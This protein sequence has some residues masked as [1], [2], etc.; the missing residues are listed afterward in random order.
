MF[1][2]DTLW[3]L[4]GI[5]IFAGLF[6][7]L[8]IFKRKLKLSFTA[9]VAIAL[10]LGIVFGILMQVLFN[11]Q[12]TAVNAVT[13]ADETVVTLGAT[14]ESLRKWINIVGTGFTKLLQFVVTP[15]VAVSI[16]T[17]FSKT[18]GA[19]GGVK[20]SALIIGFLLLTTA[21]SAVITIVIMRIS[22][23]NANNLIAAN[24]SVKEP[25]DIPTTILGLIP[26]NLF[27]A[28]SSN[29]VLSVV[30]IAVLIG[31][32]YLVIR[33]ESPKIG[34]RFQSFLDTAREF[35]MQVVD[36]VIGLTPYGVL[37]VI[38][39]RAATASWRAIT[40]LLSIIGISFVMMAVVFIL[41]LALL[42][43]LGTNPIRFFKKASPALLF[44]F[45]SRSS[46]ATLPLTI[47]AQRKLGVSDANANIAGTLGTCI[48]QNGCAGVYPVMLA[49][50]VGMAQ[51]G[52]GQSWNVWSMYFTIPLVIYAVI[53]SIGTAGVG[54]G[55]T[56]VSLV[57]LSFLG[58]PVELVGILI[59]VDFIIDMG[60]TFLNVSDSM[61]AGY[62]IGKF[63]RDINKD[64]LHDL[65]SVEDADKA[66]AAAAPAEPKAQNA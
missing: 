27:A 38:A 41:H 44:A 24:P 7:L 49:L 66:R 45:A 21:I 15:I 40:D 56:N 62:V 46:A 17:A 63:E 54:G 35:V 32:A 11:E 34:E 4:L 55:A 48:G 53:A 50:L 8:F 52:A 3:V 28:F 18:T 61:L 9:R 10:G 29:E 64:V 39:A 19:G 58:L 47:Q 60:R 23:V 51:G 36:F 22:G 2:L 57:V 59:S 12:T 65:I 37:G 33:K 31:L 26:S 1:T 16:V 30:I 5:I 20:K 13:G 42:W 6:F 14:G 43:I 25:A